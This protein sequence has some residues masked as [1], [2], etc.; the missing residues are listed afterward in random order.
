MTLLATQFADLTT[1]IPRHYVHKAAQSEVLLTSFEAITD[2]EFV[3]TAQWPRTHS[4]YDVVRG[5]HDPLLVA[6]TVRQVVPLLSHL[7]YGAPFGHRQIWEHLAWNVEPDALSGAATPAELGL[8]VRC[9][10]IVRRAS[11]LAALTMD[12][13]I[14]RNGVVLGSAVTRFANQAPAVYSRLRGAYAD[15]D[16][17]LSRCPEPTAPLD[18]RL[19]GRDRER[20]VVLSDGGAPG[21]YLL[22]VDL[23]H[24]VLFDH[25][26][27]HAPGMLLLEAARQAA[28]AAAQP[29]FA[30]ITGMD[31]R[32]LRY[33][34]FD[35]PCRIEAEP[36][37]DVPGDR[38]ATRVTAVQ[39]DHEVFTATVTA[40]RGPH[41]G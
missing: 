16:H 36:L 39:H 8:Y 27:D 10:D 9:F 5:S 25:P 13:G 21:R 19:V 7:G 15:L 22:R 28:H 11:R 18:A 3:L 4:F 35:A 23:D 34:E 32:F 2:D 41:G 26:V 20:D 30:V 12:V 6:E 29:E 37:G 31:T 33:V 14:T 40:R 1:V 24:P 17:A 38:S